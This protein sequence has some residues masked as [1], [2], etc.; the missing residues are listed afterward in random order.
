MQQRGQEPVS[1]P[2]DTEAAGGRLARP[3]HEGAASIWHAMPVDDVLASLQSGPE[4]LDGAQA[5]QRLKTYGPNR[6]PLAAGKPAWRRFLLQ[7]HNSLIYLLL[8]GAAVSLALGH[9]VDA[10][11]IVLVVVVN[12]V[13]GFIQEGR[14]QQAME[15]IRRLIAPHAT[16]L[17][18]GGRMVCDAAD[19]VPGDIVLLEP[20][21]RVTA[22]L[23]LLRSRGLMVDEAILTGESVNASKQVT[24]SMVDAPLGDRDGMAFSGTLVVA[25]MGAG[26][27]VATG[28]RTEI[29]R[30]S[31]LMHEVE[32]ISTPLLRQVD[33]FSRVFGVAVLVCAVLLFVFAVGVRGYGALDALMAVVSLA[34]AVVPEG[35]LAVMTITLAIGVQRM[36]RRQAIVRR[37]PAVETLGATSIICSDKTGTLTRNEMTAQRVVM[38]DACWQASGQGYAPQGE[39]LAQAGGAAVE[40]AGALL[41][42]CLLCNDA[43]LH[44]DEGGAWSVRGDTMEGALL[45]LAAKGGLD[46]GL[47][48]LAWPRLDEIPFDAR[49]AYM[50]TLHG[51]AAGSGVRLLFLKGAP[52]KVLG[53]CATQRTAGGETPLDRAYWDVQIAALAE[54]GQRVLGF[55]MRELGP[56]D[57]LSLNPDELA[58]DFVLLGVIGFIDPPRDEALA[59]VRDCRSAGIE[60]KMITGDHAATALAI[61]RQLGLRDQ[62]EVLGAAELDRI[63]DADL[64]DAAQRTTVFARATPE[65]KLRIVRALQARGAVV[66]MTGD[67]VNDAPA[68]KQADVGVAMG[69]KG[70]EAAK[71]ASEIVLAD[72]NFASI[73]AAV[74]EGRTV[75]DN[76]TKVISWTLPTNGGEVMVVILALMMGWVLP[77]STAQ[78]LWINLATTV[79]LGL[80]LAFEPAEPGVMARRPRPAGQPLLSGFLLWRV[81]FVSFLFMIGA[82]GIFLFLQA[83]GAP[84]E[85]ART[86]VVNVI[87]VMEV[88]YLFSVRYLHMRSFNWQGI[89]GTPAV[90]LA[91]VAVTAGQLLLTYAP[92]MQ[93]W[94][95][96]AALSPRQVV[97]VLAVGL[98]LFTLLELEKAVARR[99]LGEVV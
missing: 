1:G 89:K 69:G 99:W 2:E 43:G 33:R 31:T 39:L 82:L 93:R 16:V 63:S 79:T 35:L 58:A 73:V 7:F 15:S 37:L 36:A 26:V 54:Q 11:V 52:E 55:A 21:D 13:T 65:H 34:V 4:G 56:E 28:A 41:R 3:G 72:D 14:A 90:A 70:T 81:G 24:V 8:V 48:R 71:E 78:I 85:V 12:A 46:A 27:V 6:L 5:A 19:L 42:C 92:A 75:Y 9:G 57:A 18:D 67:G 95:Q 76:L 97:A 68:L 59:A 87:V 96:T 60:V 49:Y 50:A 88:A 94:F 47:E 51:D 84:L 45:A 80:V 38:A 17:R 20:G 44:Q 40:Q 10:A 30:I 64:P 62:P 22:D 25:G 86:A 61:A 53:R 66:A 98:A 91:L 23:R 77:M 74:K 83:R 29:G 32:A